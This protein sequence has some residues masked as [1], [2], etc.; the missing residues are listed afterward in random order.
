MSRLISRLSELGSKAIV[1]GAACLLSGC[2]S[3]VVGLMPTPLLYS[4]FEAN[5]MSHVPPEERWVP[6]RVYYATVRE[7]IADWRTVRYGNRVGSELCFGLALV[8]FGGRDMTWADLS[9]V[10]AQPDRET[11]VPLSIAGIAEAGAS[12]I[13]IPAAEVA[14]ANHAGWFLRDL[15][16]SVAAS[17]D[18]DVLVYVHGAKVDFY[19]S[20]AFA[21]Q[22][23]H[24]MGRDMTSVAYAWP[25]RQEILSYAAGWD[26]NRAYRSA[27]SL[28]TLLELIAGHSGARRIHVLCWS[29]GGRVVSA[30]MRELRERHAEL[31]DEEA[32]DLLRLGNVYF[33]A[34][35]VPLDQFLDT[36]PSVH[37]LADRVTVSASDA[38]GAL[39][40][41]KLFMGGA[42]RIGDSSGGRPALLTDETVEWLRS[43]DRLEVIDVSHGTSDRGF[44]I[45]GHDYWIRHPWASSDVLLSIRTDLPAA[46][47]GLLSVAPNLWA[48]PTDYPERLGGVA[49]ELNESGPRR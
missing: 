44:D 14:S 36:L 4:S 27:E 28:A 41:A 21:A 20:T 11:G 48:I 39:R 2:S 43:L 37:A 9:A 34:A 12:P 3:G 16:E 35:D 8:G 26:V 5:P 18:Q 23:D 46:E 31:T 47:R 6:R 13:G 45:S 42:R 15:R 24:Y 32:R 49:A 19:N 29:A 33:A 1:L 30:A 38:D 17:R 40:S 10:S 25:T 7:R 22:L